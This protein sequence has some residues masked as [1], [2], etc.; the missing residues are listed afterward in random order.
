MATD[1]FYTMLDRLKALHEEKVKD[2]GTAE[3][4][5]ANYRAAVNAGFTA[6]DSIVIRLNEKLTRLNNIYSRGFEHDNSL[7]P[8][9][10][11]ADELKDISACALIGWMLAEEPQYELG[12]DV[13]KA[14]KGPLGYS[15]NLEDEAEVLAE[16]P[17]PTLPSVGGGGGIC[18]ATYPSSCCL[19][20]LSEGHLGLHID[21]LNVHRP[22]WK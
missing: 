10:K 14:A 13:T 12:K 9:E 16:E 15:V 17:S 1:P 11:L 5:Y 7:R 21:A 6:L 3:D 19:C 20:C 4:P 2:Y 18:G 22:G 8:W